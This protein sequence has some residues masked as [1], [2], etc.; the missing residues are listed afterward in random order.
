MI[1]FK[2]VQTGLNNITTT[3]KKF[4]SQNLGTNTSSNVLHATDTV[5][6]SGVTKNKLP[7]DT[8]IANDSQSYNESALEKEA[9]EI[10]KMIKFTAR[11]AGL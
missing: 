7:I 9:F 5:C 8:L 4:G 3:V 2:S 10:E 1:N 11:F 6:M